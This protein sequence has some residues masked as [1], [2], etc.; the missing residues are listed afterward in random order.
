MSSTAKDFVVLFYQR[1]LDHLTQQI[2][3]LLA[4]SEEKELCCLAEA[5][6]VSLVWMVAVDNFVL[7]TDV[8]KAVCSLRIEQMLRMKRINLYFKC[9]A[10]FWFRDVDCTD[11]TVPLNVTIH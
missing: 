3:L 11:R 1:G 9:L 6:L 10:D 4:S 7:I 2:L 8:G 5:K